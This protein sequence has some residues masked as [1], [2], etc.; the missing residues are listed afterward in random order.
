MALSEKTVVDTRDRFD[1]LVTAREASKADSQRAVNFQQALTALQNASDALRESPSLPPDSLPPF[2]IDDA[3]AE[4]IA[5]IAKSW[6]AQPSEE[7]TQLRAELVSALTLAGPIGLSDEV[8]VTVKASLAREKGTNA[9]SETR[10][11]PSN[12]GAGKGTILRSLPRI[13]QVVSMSATGETLRPTLTPTSENGTRGN[14]NTGRWEVK[15]VVDKAS[16]AAGLDKAGQDA[17]W[18]EFVAQLAPVEQAMLND[19]N[20]DV[21]L[22]DRHG[23]TFHITY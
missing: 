3:V 22:T 11:R 2:D 21:T 12:G 14:W 4:Q 20:V 17:V 15:R 7:I 19:E 23:N 6:Q 18:S 13:P 16:Q 5:A 1:Q 10:S 8:Q 9:V